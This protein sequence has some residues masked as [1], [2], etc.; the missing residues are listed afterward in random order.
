MLSANP[1]A[2]SVVLSC[3]GFLPVS[4]QFPSFKERSWKKLNADDISS[5]PYLKQTPDRFSFRR[6]RNHVDCPP[7]I[8]RRDE[9]SIQDLGQKPGYWRVST[10]RELLRQALERRHS[11]QSSRSSKA[12]FSTPILLSMPLPTA[13]IQTTIKRMSYQS[14][15]TIW[16]ASTAHLRTALCSTFTKPKSQPTKPSTPQPDKT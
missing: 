11:E 3:L 12:S 5:I 8:D 1:L 13:K 9:G 15:R 10:S 6:E 14:H 2:S 16:A 7:C 4:R